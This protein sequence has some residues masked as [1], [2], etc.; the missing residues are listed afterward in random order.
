MRKR[1]NSLLFVLLA[2]ALQILVTLPCY[3]FSG[4][5]D[6]SEMFPNLLYAFCYSSIICGLGLLIVAITL[7]NQTKAY[8]VLKEYDD[9]LKLEVNRKGLG[10]LG[11]MSI[12]AI[13]LQALVIYLFLTI[14]GIINSVGIVVPALIILL[15]INLFVILYSRNS[16]KFAIL[17]G[18]KVIVVTG[19]KGKINVYYIN[20]IIDSSEYHLRKSPSVIHTFEFKNGKFDVFDTTFRARCLAAY[21]NARLDIL[22]H[23]SNNEVTAKYIGFPQKYNVSN[24]SIDGL[25]KLKNNSEYWT[26]ADKKVAKS[27]RGTARAESIFGFILIA[28]IAGFIYGVLYA[29]INE[30]LDFDYLYECSIAYVIIAVLFWAISFRQSILSSYSKI[31]TLEGTIIRKHVTVEPFSIITPDNLIDVKFDNGVVCNV[32]CPDLKYKSSEPGFSTVVLVKSRLSS[33]K[34]YSED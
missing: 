1:P 4:V 26:V 16:M 23:K 28:I 31:Y 6:E 33:P 14:D 21:L 10:E 13:V 12:A 11:F 18:E 32:P 5:V 22:R 25:E 29:L 7:L 34:V 30:S 9:V 15:V 20:D 19:K 3:Y 17:W 8:K 27:V 2:L 24:G